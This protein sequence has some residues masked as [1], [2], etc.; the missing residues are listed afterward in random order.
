MQKFGTREMVLAVYAI[1][2]AM[3]A[4]GY[5]SLADALAKVP[6]Y[7]LN[8][9][10]FAVLLAFCGV[11]IAYFACIDEKQIQRLQE[12]VEMLKKVRKQP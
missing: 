5:V 12:E 3:S 4:L 2:F 9:L 11:L 8:I 7:I 6:G 1:A 10:S